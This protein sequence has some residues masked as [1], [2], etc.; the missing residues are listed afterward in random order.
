MKHSKGAIKD[1]IRDKEIQSNCFAHLC[2][3]DVQVKNLQVNNEVVVADVILVTDIESGN[4]ERY[5]K[6][7]YPIHRLIEAGFLK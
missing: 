4:T 7:E 5:N 6:C 3:V 1:A 2:G